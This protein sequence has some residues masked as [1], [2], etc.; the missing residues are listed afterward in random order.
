M[1]SLLLLQLQV[2]F[3]L[4]KTTSLLIPGEKHPT[5]SHSHPC[6]TLPTNNCVLVFA[7]ALLPGLILEAEGRG[8]RKKN[9]C[10]ASRQAVIKV[11]TDHPLPDS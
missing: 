7:V 5:C 3:A 2:R 10:H 9:N 11:L 6:F 8:R 4:T 1:T